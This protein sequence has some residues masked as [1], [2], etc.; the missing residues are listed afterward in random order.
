MPVAVSYPGVYLEEVPSGVRTIAA[1]ATS[2]TAFLG[3][4]RRGPVDAPVVINS[5]G[6]FERVFGGLWIESTLGFA[7]RDF[8][9]N[10]G[11]QAIIV[12]LF[13]AGTATAA[14]GT[15]RRPR[16]TAPGSLARAELAIGTLTLEAANE[17]AWG[18]ALRVRVDHAVRPDD[19]TL[20]NVAVKDDSSGRVELFRNV[21]VAADH[22]R[23]IDNV[24]RNESTLLR[25]SGD[26]PKERPAPHPDP[27]SGADAFGDHT[28]ATNI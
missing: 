2:V 3:R 6:D 26:L 21:S 8:Y 12:R 22:V 27:P 14:T 28:P 20:F 19:D 13:H 16:A 18:N 25:T 4:A 24:L 11:S 5:F 10:G 7:V 15:T 1:V 9:L 23:R 17:G